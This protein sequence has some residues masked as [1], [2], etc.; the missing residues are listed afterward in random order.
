MAQKRIEEKL[1]TVDQEISGIRAELHGLPSIRED[2]SSLAK[3]VERQGVQA[4][5]QQQQQQTFMKYIEA[6]IKGKTTIT[7]EEVPESKIHSMVDVNESMMMEGKSE[8][9]RS[10]MEGDDSA[11]DRSKFKKIEMPVFV[12]NDPESW[13]FRAE[14][15]FQIHKLTESEK[16]TVSINFDGAAL[17]WYRSHEGHDPFVNWEDLKRRLLVRFRSGLA[18]LPFLQKAVIDETFMNGLK[19]WIKAELEC[20]EPVGLAQMMKLAQKVENREVIRGEASFKRGTVPMRTITLRGM[21][22]EPNR[23][24]GPLKRLSDAEFQARRMIRGRAIVVL[25]DCGA[26]HNFI[27]DKLVTQLL[28]LEESSHYGV[29]LGS[30]SAV[31]GKGICKQVELLQ[32]DWKIVNNFLPLELGGVDIILGMQWLHTL[33]VTE[34]DWRKLTLT[35]IQNGK[36]VALRGDPSLTKV[37]VSLKHMMKTWTEY[38]QG[39]LIE[40]RAL[41]GGIAFAELYGI[42]AVPTIHKS[43]PTVLAKYED[44][45]YWPGG[46]PPHRAIEHHIHLKKGTNL[47]NV[48]P[49]RYAYQQKEETERLVD[50]MMASGIIKPSTSPY[51]SPVLLRELFDE[52]NGASMFSNI[53]LKAGYH[54]IRMCKEDVE[55]TAFRTHEG[56]YEFLVM[57][58]GLN[59]PSTF[60]A[61]MNII[62]KP[63]L[64]RFVLVFFDDILIYSRSLEEHLQHLELVLEVL[65]ENELYAN[66]NKCEFAKTKVEYL[67][68]II[69]G[70]GVEVD[71]EKIRSIKE[72]P[73]PTNVREVRGFLG[74]TGYYRRFVRNYGSMATPLTQLLKKGVYE[75]TAAA[76]EV[77]EKLKVAMMTLPILALPDFSLP[78]EIETDASGYGVGAVLIQNNRPIAYFSQTLAMRGR[79]KSVYERELMAVVLAVQRWRPYLLGKRFVVKTDQQS[80]KFLLEQRV[81]QPQHQRWVA[82]LLGYNFDVVYKPGLENKAADAL[83]RVSPTA[84]L[85]QLTASSLLDVSILRSEVDGDEKLQEIVAKL[86][87]GEDVA[88]FTMQNVFGGHSGYLRTYKRLIG[89]L[90]WEGMKADDTIWSEISMDFIDG[91]PKSEGHE[92]ILV[93]VDRLSKYGH[94]IALKHPYTAKTVADAFV[95]E[96]VKLH[97]YPKS[98]VSD[99]NKVFL[100]HFWQEM[101]WL[102]DTKLSRSTAYHPQ[103]NGQTEDRDVILGILKEHL[104]VAQDKMK[105]YAAQKRRHVEFQEGDMVFLKLRPYRQV[106]VRKKRNEKLS[107]KFFGSF[108]VIARIGPVA[109]KLELPPTAAIHP[110]FH[111]SQLKVVGNHTDVHS[112]VPFLTENVE[113][114]AI[115]ADI[116]GYRQHP[117]TKEWE[118]LIGWQGL[119]SHEATWENCAVFAQQFPHFHLED[120]VSLE[121]GSNATKKWEMLI[122]W[123]GIPPHEATWEN[124]DDL[125]QQF[126]HFQLEDKG[127]ESGGS[128]NHLSGDNSWLHRGRLKWRDGRKDGVINFILEVKAAVSWSSGMQ[129]CQ[130]ILV[131]FSLL[132]VF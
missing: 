6:M 21:A 129:K 45:F 84:H 111:V 115:P 7:M 19:P 22:G 1:K 127:D 66:M 80:L 77:F 37:R 27:S 18:P 123:E 58:F 93:V 16:M 107:P 48:R 42:D 82:K 116:F 109:Y 35:F 56:H 88:G 24:E 69:S 114:M 31:K 38:D 78:F 71:P 97:G 43:I 39:F 91:L 12:G 67:G 102:S 94:F 108:K 14:R 117:P 30:R 46:L 2:F 34:V 85:N 51:S 40:C 73:V 90:Y 17:D 20:W 121:K 13:L 57:P 4:E 52:L 124:C 60:Q 86:E 113:W 10:R 41:E 8:E 65:R 75:W 23:R 95:K 96:V 131:L 55:K 98:I 54:Q 128:G 33:G 125:V 103:S 118:V 36:K 89:E 63:Y 47:V 101:F 70:K 59:A 26:T 76:H 64:R 99:R 44:I 92:V 61:L 79:A 100:S 29:I 119:P 53:D 74:L 110:V 87:E 68:H 130:F 3:S 106:S 72:W 81:I 25:I 11:G 132:S 122:S 112:L 49:Y 15:Y 120:K 50:E 5:Q 104:R 105:K 28:L 126:P 32:G 9:R 83:S 62:F